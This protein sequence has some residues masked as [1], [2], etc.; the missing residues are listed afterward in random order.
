MRADV[1][2]GELMTARRMLTAKR[3]KLNG[4]FPSEF[5]RGEFAAMEAL[6]RRLE[7]RVEVLVSE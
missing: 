3:N 5:E 2:K 4:T 7:K 1:L 6:K